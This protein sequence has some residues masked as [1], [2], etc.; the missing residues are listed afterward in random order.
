[1]AQVISCTAAEKKLF[2]P[3]RLVGYI[4]SFV[5][6]NFNANFL[7]NMYKAFEFITYEGDEDPLGCY[8]TNV[9]SYI[10]GLAADGVTADGVF[11]DENDYDYELNPRE[12]MY[13]FDC[14]YCEESVIIYGEETC[15]KFGDDIWLV[16]SDSIRH[17]DN[18]FMDCS[19]FTEERLA[20]PYMGTQHGP[21]L[22]I[23][24]YKYIRLLEEALR[25]KSTGLIAYMRDKTIITPD[26][27][28]YV[29]IK[30]NHQLYAPDWYS[31]ASDDM[32]LSLCKD[33]GVLPVV[34]GM[35]I[36][37]KHPYYIGCEDALNN[38]IRYNLEVVKKIVPDQICP[39]CRLVPYEV[40]YDDYDGDQRFF[41]LYTPYEYWQMT[42]KNDVQV[43]I[44][45]EKNRKI[46]IVGCQEAGDYL[47]Q[48][49]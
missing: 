36:N 32:L 16:N 41:D 24:M 31:L 39:D 26:M 38:V 30:H 49:E 7:L 46:E 33:F 25:M 40:T 23:K 29:Y 11:F 44:D 34:L 42:F 12:V 1:M 9:Q 48:L 20:L 3:P 43:F 4:G 15:E 18:E 2:L 45:G 17:I 10:A 5:K 14:F 28:L 13:L 19:Q 27:V 8:K 6:A 21:E 47:R 37:G 22:N 35:A